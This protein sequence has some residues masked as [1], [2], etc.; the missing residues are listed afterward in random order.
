MGGKNVLSIRQLGHF[1]TAKPALT[2]KKKNTVVFCSKQLAF[3]WFL[4]QLDTLRKVG[5]QIYFGNNMFDLGFSIYVLSDNSARVVFKET[6]K[7][8]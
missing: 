5:K 1:S 7:G 3:W 4:S 8:V 6:S 2:Q